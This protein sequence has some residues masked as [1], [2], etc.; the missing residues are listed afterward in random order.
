[1]SGVIKTGDPGVEFTISFLK[2]VNQKTRVKK[3][4][5]K[6]ASIKAEKAEQERRLK[7]A[8]NTNKDSLPSLESKPLELN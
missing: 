8:N 7:E 4:E 2:S 1:M 5:A 3:L 6:V